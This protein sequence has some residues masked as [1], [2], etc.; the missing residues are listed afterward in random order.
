MQVQ[1]NAERVRSLRLEHGMTKR[2]LARAAGISESTARS[3]ERGIPVRGATGR[4]V[5]R[6]LGVDPPQSLGRVAR[7]G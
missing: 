3:A 4:K 7:R 5:A 6:V 2:D 1:L